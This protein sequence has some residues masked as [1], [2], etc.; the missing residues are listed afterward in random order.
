MNDI[1]Q[2]LPQML[3][4]H[5]FIGLDRDGT[6]VPY[7]DRP[8]KAIP[9]PRLIST[10]FKL[11]A[12][13][14][15]TIAVVSARSVA[16]L[17]ADFGDKQLILAGNYGLEIFFPG[18]ISGAGAL[19]KG[20]TMIVQNEAA[21]VVSQLKQVRDNLA[22]LA[23]P[24]RDAILEDH[25][26]SL[27]LHWHTVPQSALSELHDAVNATKNQF[28]QLMFRRL[29][30]SYEVLPGFPWDKSCALDILEE[31]LILR[32]DRCFYLFA[33]DSPADEPAFVWVNKRHGV[34]IKVGK[35]AF[36]SCANYFLPDPAT[37][38]DLLEK[39]SQWRS[40][41]DTAAH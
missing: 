11:A 33:G 14:Q 34:S 23:E 19:V 5:L 41:F 6:L 25:G 35:G 22:W 16:L 24:G 38:A 20:P 17:Q 7:A 28:A 15:V 8:E 3:D 27:C 9:E 31:K 30:T 40:S 1:L 13:P 36:L 10:L 39:L 29:P 32:R 2:M 21:R 26:L 12:M 37:F 18:D 4:Q